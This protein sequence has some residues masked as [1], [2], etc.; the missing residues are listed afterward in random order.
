LAELGEHSRADGDGNL[1]VVGD[2]RHSFVWVAV[3]RVEER[4][5]VP[6]DLVFGSSGLSASLLASGKEWFSAWQFALMSL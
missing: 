4:G 1:L 2:S 6:R 3:Q 5:D